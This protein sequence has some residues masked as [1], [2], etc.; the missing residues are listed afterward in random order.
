MEHLHESLALAVEQKGGRNSVLRNGLSKHVLPE[1][2]TFIALERFYDVAKEALPDSIVFLGTVGNDLILSVKE[3]TGSKSKKRNRDDEIN[4]D[5]A[6]S[7]L[8]GTAPEAEINRTKDL[9][10][11]LY[12]DLR[13]SYEE[14]AIMATAVEF[15]KLQANDTTA[16]AVVAVRVHSGVPLPLHRLKSSLGESWVDGVVTTTD[17]ISTI[18]C[19]LPPLSAEGKVALEGGNVSWVFL[20]SIPPLNVS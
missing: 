4:I 18:A 12:R 6:L 7:R 19:S 13:G 2:I 5:L 20:T 3:T 14:P 16:R 9:L 1:T 10:V 8:K 17:S 11:R 15:T